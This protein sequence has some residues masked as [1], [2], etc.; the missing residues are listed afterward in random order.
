[1]RESC[2]YIRRDPAPAQAKWQGLEYFVNQFALLETG[3]EV[4]DLF[5]LEINVTHPTQTEAIRGD[6]LCEKM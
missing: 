2:N 1:M 3:V 5:Y 4:I 6:Q